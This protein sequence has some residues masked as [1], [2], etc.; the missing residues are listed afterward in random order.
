MRRKRRKE[1]MRKESRELR[2][3]KRG[4]YRG[5]MR[6]EREERGRGKGSIMSSILSYYFGLFSFSFIAVKRE[7][8]ERRVIG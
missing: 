1:F 4:D 6:E 2:E 7:G 5:K 8:R 3:R